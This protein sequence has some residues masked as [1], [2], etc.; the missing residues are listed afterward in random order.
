MTLAAECHCGRVRV[1]AP[2]PPP[3][4]NECSC[5]VCYKYGALWAYYRKDTVTIEVQGHPSVSAAD[6]AATS[7]EGL[8]GLDVYIRADDDGRRAHLTFNRCA[9]CGCMTH[10]SCV[11]GPESVEPDSLV[12][13]NSRL[14]DEAQLVGVERR[15]SPGP[16]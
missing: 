13:V 16:E 2:G 11:A 7:P 3:Y 15:P 4:R 8:P 9:H 1:V 6:A 12:G 10:W 5:S 14:M